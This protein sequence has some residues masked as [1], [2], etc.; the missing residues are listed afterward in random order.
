MNERSHE[1]HIKD[2]VEVTQGQILS[3]KKTHF[4]QVSI[5]TRQAEQTKA[6]VFFALKGSRTD[7]HQFLMSAY[8]NQA[9]VLVVES[10]QKLESLPSKITIIKVGNVLQALG[11]WAKFFRESQNFKVVGVT[12]SNGKTSVKHFCQILF[13]DDPSVSVS[14]KSYNNHIGVALSLLQARPGTQTVIQEIGTNQ[15]GEIRHLCS[16]AQ[17]DIVVCTSVGM[18]HL[19]GFG[20]IQKIAEEKEQIY[21][22]C[23]KAMGLFSLDNQWT[24]QMRKR[25]SGRTMSFSSQEDVADVY[26][27]IQKVEENA[28]HIDGRIQDVKSQCVLPLAGKHHLNNVMV[29]VTIGLAL[30]KTPENIWQSLPLWKS[31]ERRSQLQALGLQN[32]LFFDAYNSNPESMQAFLEHLAIIKRTKKS[33]VLCV[34]DMLELGDLSATLHQELGKKVG[35]MPFDF[36]FYIGQYRFDFERGLKEAGTS[37]NYELFETYQQAISEKILSCLK[38]QSLLAIKAS[39]GLQLERVWY[40]VQSLIQSKRKRFV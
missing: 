36:I 38:S 31:P 34:G 26:M 8:Q 15:A 32:F 7:G 2:L 24:R 3:Q 29:A 18:A 37:K 25:F 14:P 10:D 1:F 33:C 19:G 13:Q 12:G 23:P 30:G 5:D 11:K 20:S 40:D 21:I 6:S 28:L 22:S 4:N 27:I 16:I 9:H 17:P 35:Q 39:R